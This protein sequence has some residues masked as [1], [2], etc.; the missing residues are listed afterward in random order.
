MIRRFRVPH[1]EIYG[2]HRMN[3]YPSKDS[4]VAVD[5]FNPDEDDD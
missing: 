3:Y 1:D 2:K 5:Y 4:N